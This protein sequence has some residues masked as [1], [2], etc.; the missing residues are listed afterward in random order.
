MEASVLTFFD[1]LAVYLAVGALAGVLAGLLGVGG[2]LVI[3][4]A[5]VWVFRARGIDE[6]VVV[7]LAVG[8]SL[9]AIVPTA[10]SSMYAH[11]RR[12]AVRWGLVARLAPGVVLGAWVG[13]ALADILPTFWLQRAFA[14]FALAAGVRM[15]V[16]RQVEPRRGLPGSWGLVGA[17]TGIGSVSALVGI[18]GGSLT[19]P[20]LAGCG[21]AMRN[22]V[23]TSSACGLPLALAGAVGF[24]AAGWGDG[25]LPRPTAG[26]VHGYAAVAVAAASASLAPVGA[27]LAHRLPVAALRRVFGVLLAGI[28][29]RMLL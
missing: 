15:L 28:G 4:P 24:I 26:F 2:G 7:H 27:W 19:V 25:R 6:A 11:H 23:A 1:A 8:T 22:A 5:L 12:A 21:V 29:A 16:S 17:G 18:G 3:V 13:A 14:L 9:A 10:A 20:F